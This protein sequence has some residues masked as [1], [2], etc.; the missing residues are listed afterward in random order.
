[1]NNIEKKKVDRF[2]FLNHLYEIT[3]G[4]QLDNRNML[5]IGKVLGMTEEETEIAVQYLR[6]EGLIEPMTL[7]SDCITHNGVVQVE[8]ALS[9]PESPTQYFP[10]INY[11]HVES[12]NNSQIQQ[13]TQGS[14]Q[15]LNLNASE[16]V[17]IEEIISEIKSAIPSLNLSPQTQQ[18]LNGEIITLEGQLQTSKPKKS[19]IKE[20][21]IS[22]K[23][24]LEQVSATLLASK[25][26]S[27]LGLL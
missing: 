21:L 11:I 7:E 17:Q 6:E 3:N 4:N 18:D 15:T 24:I 27:L 10:A 13:A 16:K 22:L 1:M 25:I 26:A 20:A 2:R 19:I 9:H 5:D 12:M 8:E 14:T 23:T